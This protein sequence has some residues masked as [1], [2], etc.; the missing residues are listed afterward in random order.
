MKFLKGILTFLFLVNLQ[1]N[2]QVPDSLADYLSQISFH[3]KTDS[4][5]LKNEAIIRKI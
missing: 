3:Q 4:V 5:F 1:A 2:A